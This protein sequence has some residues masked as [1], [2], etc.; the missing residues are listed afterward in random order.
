VLKSDICLGRQDAGDKMF[1]TC[2]ALNIMLLGVD[3]LDQGWGN[4]ALSI[5]EGNLGLHDVNDVYDHLP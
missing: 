2:C 4:G 5:C 1:L 3:G